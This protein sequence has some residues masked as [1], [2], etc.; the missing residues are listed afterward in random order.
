MLAYLFDPAEPEFAAEREL[1][2]N[3]RVRRARIIVERC[4]QLGAPITWERVMAIAGETNTAVGRPHVASAL[5]EAG[6]VATVDA[7]F[8]PDWL[9][10]GGRAYVDKYAIDAA[11]AVA[12]V[13]AAGGVTVFAHPGAHRRG[14]TVTEHDIADLAAVGLTGI[15]VDH[16]DHDEETRAELRALGTDLGLVLT[17][18]SDYHGARKAIPLG[19]YTTDPREYEALVARAT[20][21]EVVSG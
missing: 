20:G 5:V 7:A 6:V 17:G 8:T 2:R 12:L 13:R 14:A 19:A 21:T 9:A 10:D 3:D 11:R 18:S 16:A 4:Q 15:E 1:L